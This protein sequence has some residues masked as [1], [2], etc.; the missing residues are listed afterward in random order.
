MRK[1]YE[2]WPFNFG[3]VRDQ[4]F[5]KSK[6]VII[7]MPYEGTVSLYHGTSAGPY[8]IIENSR[9][10]DEMVDSQQRGKL[11]SF[12][13]EDIFTLDEV[14][15]SS[16]TTTEALEGVRQVVTDIALKHNK[17]PLMLGG[18]HSITL[19]AVKAIK[20]KYPKV[21]VLQFDAHPDLLDQYEGNRYSHASV[22]RRIRDLKVPVVSLGIR[23]TNPQSEHYIKKNHIKNIYFG[24]HLPPI[25]QVLKGLTRDVYLTFDLDCFDTG[26]MPSVGTPEPGGFQWQEI[27]E[28]LGQICKR[29]NLIGADVV[30]LKPIPGLEA[31][32]FLAAKLVYYI[33]KYKLENRGARN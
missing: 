10:L 27:I 16:G 8:A 25:N 23:N 18:E 2:L 9:Y 30:E 3:A 4:N 20:K 29:V 22:M 13:S 26:I 14:E 15:V 19:G 6:V 17:F 28:Y 7:P 31:P 21:S 11:A 24:A 33:I 12:N 32:N 5:E 1:L